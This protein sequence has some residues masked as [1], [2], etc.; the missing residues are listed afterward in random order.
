MLGFGPIKISGLE[1][2][3]KFLQKGNCSVLRAEIK[4]K[5]IGCGNF[6][7]SGG[8]EETFSYA[9]ELSA[10]NNK[11]QRAIF[12]KDLENDIESAGDVICDTCHMLNVVAAEKELIEKIKKIVTDIEVWM[13]VPKKDLFNNGG[14]EKILQAMNN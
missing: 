3:I 14:Y 10:K 8:N 12:V 5:A 2:F 1:E 9:I 7:E 11:G 13:I 4:R 6:K